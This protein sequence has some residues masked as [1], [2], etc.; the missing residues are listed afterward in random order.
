MN[1]IV[2]TQTPL[3]ELKA[4]PDPPAGFE[5]P[6]SKGGKGRVEERRVEEGRV[7]NKRGG[8]RGENST[9]F[10]SRP[11]LFYN[12][13]TCGDKL[14]KSGKTENFPL[15]KFWGKSPKVTQSASISSLF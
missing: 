9:T 7:E 2:S 11:N 15:T 3:R 12:S 14:L 10:I 8:R 5:G 6:T 1:G 13:V 4:F